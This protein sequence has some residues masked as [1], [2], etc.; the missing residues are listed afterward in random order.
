MEDKNNYTVL[1][2]EDEHPSRRVLIDYVLNRPELELAGIAVNLEAAMRSL[3]SGDYDL[4][5]L[6]PRL[7]MPGMQ[8]LQSLDNVPSS[9]FTSGNDKYAVNAFDFGAVDY[10]V[11]PFSLERFNL[12]IDKFITVRENIRTLNPAMD[13]FTFMERRKPRVI[14]L[15]DI[16]YFSSHGK[17]TIIHTEE[18]DFETARIL[19]DVERTLPDDIFTRIHKQY[20]VNLQY[21][22]GLKYD[23]GGRYLVIISGDDDDVLPVGRA[24][25]GSVKKRF[26]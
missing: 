7:F 25:A 23:A 18:K 5:L 12:A 17:H 26:F 22:T 6:D 3:R 21:V 13:D 19:K 9:I 14:P 11:K 4:L 15:K 16:I 10:L 20:I 1:I 24:F 2:V 8:V